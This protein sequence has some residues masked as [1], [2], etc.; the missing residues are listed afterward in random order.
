[1][2]KH[3]II[4]ILASFCNAS[5]I[6]EQIES[7]GGLRQFKNSLANILNTFEIDPENYRQIQT[8]IL[9]QID[10]RGKNQ[11]Q[12]MA[13]CVRIIRATIDPNFEVLKALIWCNVCS[14]SDSN[15][16]ISVSLNNAGFA[17]VAGPIL[18]NH[19]RRKRTESTPEPTSSG[20][21]SAVRKRPRR[22]SPDT[23]SGLTN[24]TKIVNQ[25][26]FLDLNSNLMFSGNVKKINM[27]VEVS[28][29]FKRVYSNGDPFKLQFGSPPRPDSPAGRM[30][31]F[32]DTIP[33]ERR[34]E[35]LNQINS[36]TRRL[37]FHKYVDSLQDPNEKL[38]GEYT[39]SSLYAPLELIRVLAQISGREVIPGL[40]SPPTATA[41]AEFFYQQNPDYQ[42]LTPEHILELYYTMITNSRFILFRIEDDENSSSL[43]LAYPSTYLCVS[44]WKESILGLRRIRLEKTAVE[45]F[46]ELPL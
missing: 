37:E 24:A 12:I 43:P 32:I 17:T 36:G 40:P 1:M 13:E 10:T 2:F 27:S 42:Y 6:V 28:R 33:A 11:T 22:Q 30:I 20:D 44:A 8:Q 38:Y 31:D 23:L 7:A 5:N 35:I 26:H 45:T 29:R 15:T 25:L 34:L 16:L 19:L 21:A 39:L 4:L 3:L 14:K 18:K 46:W 9:P 41:I